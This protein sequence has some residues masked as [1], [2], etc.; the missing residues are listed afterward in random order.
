[1]SSPSESASSLSVHR[2]FVVPFVVQFR[3]E[4]DI[5][6]GQLTGRVEHV[7]SRAA[8]TFDSTT[9]LLA[10]MHRM[11]QQHRDAADDHA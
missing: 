6:A 11:L 8:T 1:M 7:A 5:E 4:T 3:A 10:F 9:D 2:A